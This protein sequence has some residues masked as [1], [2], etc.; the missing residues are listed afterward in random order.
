MN[1]IS[2]LASVSP[3]AK[4]GDNIEI[5]PFAFVDDDVEIGDGCKIFPHATV[6]Q[7]V[8]MGKNCQI[9][10]G[11]VVGAVPQ[12]LK[13][14]GE[15]TSVELGDNVTV[16]ECAT[17]NRGTKAS[18]KYVTKIGSDTL[19]M[20]YS[21]VAHDCVIGN[22]CILVSYVG[23]AGETVV[24]DWAIIG[25]GS[26][27]HQFSKVG[28]HAMVGG[29]SKINKD[30]PPYVLCGRDPITYAGVNIVGLRRRGFSPE[31]IRNIKDIYETIYFSGYNIS[32]GCAKVEAGF[33]QS[34]ERDAILDFIKNS[35]RGIIRANDSREKGEYE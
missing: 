25:G 13:F 2:N 19:I 32:D 28:R 30:V 20:S 31:V 22:H 29:M 26:K 8:K 34:E 15:I 1:I 23:L 11:A 33:P 17:I 3:K 27:A 9:Y 16:R 7:Y 12:D 24:D 14:E 5:G 35:K 10:P 21:H 6:F 4:L 18:G